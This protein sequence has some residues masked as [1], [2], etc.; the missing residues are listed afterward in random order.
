MRLNLMILM[1]ALVAIGACKRSETTQST[2]TTA[3]P[4][5]N[6]TSSAS[7]AKT[8]A[9][10][11]EAAN[12]SAAPAATDACALLTTKEIET[13]QGEPLKTTQLSGRSRGGFT[14]SQCFFTLPTFTNSISLAVTQRAK[15]PDGRDPKEFWEDRFDEDKKEKHKHEREKGEEEEEESG[16]PKRIAG[17]GDEAFWIASRV[18]GALYVLKGNSYLTVSIGGAADEKTKI[19]KSKALA[20][21]ALA[22]LG[23]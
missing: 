14:V 2:V 4:T 7:P 19:E 6:E 5:A 20:R 3:T 8:E 21:K 23:G 16:P 10:A 11:N 1:V 9:S 13:I 17:V 22:R 18:G 12:S 15:A